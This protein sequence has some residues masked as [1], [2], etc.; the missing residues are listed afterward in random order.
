VRLVGL[1]VL[2]AWAETAEPPAP[3][4]PPVPEVPIVPPPAEVEDRHYHVG[5]VDTG[6]RYRNG[7]PIYDTVAV[8]EADGRPWSGFY[9]RF[10]YPCGRRTAP[11][12]S[13]P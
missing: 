1:G 13:A 8:P 12:H 6:R 5:L 7:R 3:A 4:T 10:E 11:K 2:D 9:Q